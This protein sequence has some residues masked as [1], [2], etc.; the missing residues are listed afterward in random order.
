MNKEKLIR[1]KKNKKLDLAAS[2]Y[3]GA[4]CCDALEHRY[5]AIERKSKMWQ[6]ATSALDHHMSA[7]DRKSALCLVRKLRSHAATY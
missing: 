6:S 1:K 4:D 7:I 5:R 3:V 2:G